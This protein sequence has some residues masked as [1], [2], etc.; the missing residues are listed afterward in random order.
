MRASAAQQTGHQSTNPSSGFRI[1]PRGTATVRPDAAKPRYDWQSCLSHRLHS[2]DLLPP[3]ARWSQLSC[4]ADRASSPPCPNAATSPRP[5]QTWQSW[6]SWQTFP[7]ET[8]SAPS[9]PH[10][11][12]SLPPLPLRRRSPLWPLVMSASKGLGVL[13]TGKSLSITRS[14]R[15]SRSRPS[16]I[17]AVQQAGTMA[18]SDSPRL[19]DACARIGGLAESCPLL[20]SP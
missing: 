8:T 13:L 6:Q 11:L 4:A 20:A 15:R 7:S 18:A 16:T 2:T 14:S 9:T 19:E 1:T 10:R 5:R 17:S 3:S 12:T